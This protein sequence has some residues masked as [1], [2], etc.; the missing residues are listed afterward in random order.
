MLAAVARRGTH[1][2]LRTVEVPVVPPSAEDFA[3]A[4]RTVIDGARAFDSPDHAPDP[5]AD[6]GPSGALDAGVD[7][8][9]PSDPIH[10]LPTQ[11]ISAR[12]GSAC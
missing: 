10:A 9:A 2:D 8:A 6:P 7:P 12:S 5:G 4:P 1:D 3:E 11:Q